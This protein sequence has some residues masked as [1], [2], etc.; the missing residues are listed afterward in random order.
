MNSRLLLLAT[1]ACIPLAAFAQ[2]PGNLSAERWNNLPNTPSFL[3][4]TA[5]GIAKREPDVTSL[6]PGAQWGSNVADRYGV[7]LR[8]T[9]TA[10]L[11][12]DYTFYIAGDDN[13]E[14][15]LSSDSSRFNKR[16][17]AWNLKYTAPLAWTTYPSQR[18]R[19]IQLIGGQKPRKN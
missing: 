11:T 14:L 18:S 4:L 9:V 2:T 10:P 6:Q 8:G 16:K 1:A 3:T 12:G 19:T 13:A 7:R 17:I 5:D 15:W